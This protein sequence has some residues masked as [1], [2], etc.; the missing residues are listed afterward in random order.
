MPT[1]RAPAYP[2]H[3]QAERERERERERESTAAFE[4]KAANR[5]SVDEKIAMLHGQESH[6]DLR[7]R[8]EQPAR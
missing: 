8:S 1:T 5:V 2:Y 6:G 3:M 4:H 7:T